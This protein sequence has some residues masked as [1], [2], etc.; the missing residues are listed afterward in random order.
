MRQSSR[1]CLSDSLGCFPRSFPLARA[2]AMPSRG[3]H[4]DEVGLELGEG[5]EDVEEHLSHRIGR[6][7]ERPAEGQLHASFPKPVG[8]GARIRDGSCQPIELR[9]DQRVAF[10]HGGEGLVEAGAC[11]GGAGETVIG[12]DAILCN[13]QLQE[14]L[15]LS[16]QVLPVGGAARISDE[17]CRHGK[18]YG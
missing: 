8:D 16:F 11:A 9:H 12:V 17:R 2:M 18:L 3:A 5:G 6:V 15:A 14:G 1:C 4:A 10:A 7:V 13:A